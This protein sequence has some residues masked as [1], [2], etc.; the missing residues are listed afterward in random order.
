MTLLESDPYVLTQQ[1]SDIG[2]KGKGEVYVKI[3]GVPTVS[4]ERNLTFGL[5]SGGTKYT[6]FVVPIVSSRVSY[7]WVTQV[8][9][10]SCR[11]FTSITLS[12]NLSTCLYLLLIQ[13]FNFV[14]RLNFRSRHKVKSDPLSLR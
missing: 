5:Y 8:V 11:K 2:E 14:P 7:K 10:C 1:R 6:F 4:P 13:C 3:E 9:F 12:R